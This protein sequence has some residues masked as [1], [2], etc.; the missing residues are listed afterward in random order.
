MSDTDA[1]VVYAIGARDLINRMVA[2]TRAL[3][4]ARF[5]HDRGELPLADAYRTSAAERQSQLDYAWDTTV[6]D[7]QPM[8]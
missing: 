8:I 7:K 1:A 3:Y 4:C 5:H 2:L 6:I